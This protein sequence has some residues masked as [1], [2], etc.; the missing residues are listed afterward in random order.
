MRIVAMVEFFPP[1]LGSDLRIHELLGRLSDPQVDCD[2][3]T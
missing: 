1:S 2:P 3:G